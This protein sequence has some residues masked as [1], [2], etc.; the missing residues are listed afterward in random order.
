MND[1]IITEKRRTKYK[2]TLM[3]KYNPLEDEQCRDFFSKPEV[4]HLLKKTDG[5][6]PQK[7]SSS[8][9]ASPTLGLYKYSHGVGS[10]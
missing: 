10:V 1:A 2:D 7:S 6:R 3:P 8:M 9:A 5:V 4:K